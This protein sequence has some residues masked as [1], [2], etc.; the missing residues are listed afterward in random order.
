MCLT[1]AVE[2]WILDVIVS[3]RCLPSPYEPVLI[4]HIDKKIRTYKLVT[5]IVFEL[6]TNQNCMGNSLNNENKQYNEVKIVKLNK[7]TL[8]VP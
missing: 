1:H 5:G 8:C 6:F 4:A 3:L 2:F 7:V